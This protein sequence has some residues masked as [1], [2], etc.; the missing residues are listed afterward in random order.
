MAVALL[1]GTR[2]RVRAGMGAI[3]ARILAT[4]QPSGF[5]FLHRSDRTRFGANT[6]PRASL[7]HGGDE[8]QPLLLGIAR[9]IF[10]C[11]DSTADVMVAKDIAGTDNHEDVSY[12]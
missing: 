6:N 7:S 2:R 5:V 9:Q 4:C 3:K 10:R 1:G 12:P 8:A 11:A